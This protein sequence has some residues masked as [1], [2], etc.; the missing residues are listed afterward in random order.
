MIEKRFIIGD[1][2]QLIDTE[3]GDIYLFVSEVEHLVNGLSEEVEKLKKSNKDLTDKF[4]VAED[5]VR[6]TGH[7]IEY[8]DEEERWK[9]E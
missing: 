2:G 6:D 5:F 7:E 8:S 9:I 3:T 4:D 1:F